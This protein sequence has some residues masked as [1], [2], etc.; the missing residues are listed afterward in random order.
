[1]ASRILAR[2][3]ALA[4]AAALSRAGADAAQPLAGARALSS[5]PRY[6][7]AAGSP[8]GLGKVLGYEP[9][10]HLSGTQV[11]PRRFSTVPS[12]GSPTQKAQISETYKSGT[13]VEQSDAQKSK[14]GATPKVV[15]FSP[16]EAAMAKPRSGPLT[17]E[18]SK[19]KR[20]ELATQVTFYMIP[21]LLLSSRN[22]ISTSLMV[23]AVFHQVYMFHK[24]IFLDYV[25]H[26]IS[27]KW[28]LIY[29]K[30]LLLI[31]AKD[32]L[33]CFDLV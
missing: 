32:T 23:G 22:C 18:S 8:L 26:D 21:A 15:A 16:L 13:A 4:L 1:M 30:I 7:A 31:M 25:H 24:E 33:I 5:I 19:V 20:S 12:N 10:S 3:K 27:R 6:S 29:F 11:L 2:S 14:D 9:R 28:A 17:S